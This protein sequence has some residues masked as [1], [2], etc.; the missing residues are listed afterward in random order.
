MTEQERITYEAF[1]CPKCRQPMTGARVFD[2]KAQ[3]AFVGAVCVPCDAAYR[4]SWV[5]K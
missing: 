1:P 4:V 5:A 2:A 3:E